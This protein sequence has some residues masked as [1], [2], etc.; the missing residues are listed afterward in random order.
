MTLN[1][2]LGLPLFLGLVFFCCS[3]F[4]LF[5]C[6]C[7]RSTTNDE[8]TETLVNF[9]HFP[10]YIHW[11]HLC[12]P[13]SDHWC[14]NRWRLSRGD[15][16][17]KYVQSSFVIF[18]QNHRLHSLLHTSFLLTQQFLVNVV[19]RHNMLELSPL[20]WTRLSLHLSINDCFPCLLLC[21]TILYSNRWFII[22]LFSYKEMALENTAFLFCCCSLVP[23]TPIARIAAFCDL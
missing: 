14:Y 17:S 5:C 18:I 22:L 15:A 11:L 2:Q 1:H 13:I 19:S 7:S 21:G 20:Y 3:C 23:L 16:K 8:W 6:S 4:P 10:Q 9:T 12:F